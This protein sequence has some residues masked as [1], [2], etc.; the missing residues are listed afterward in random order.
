[1]KLLITLLLVCGL[2][3]DELTSFSWFL[4]S[5]DE[6]F[7]SALIDSDYVIFF[8][9]LEDLFAHLKQNYRKADRWKDRPSFHPLI[10]SIHGCKV[11]VTARKELQPM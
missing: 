3:P 6:R 11:Q 2:G 10:H 8:F 1:M 5:S 4:S 7:L 9:F